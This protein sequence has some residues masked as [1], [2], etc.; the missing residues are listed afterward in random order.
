[1]PLPTQVHSTA[2]AWRRSTTTAKGGKSMID[3]SIRQLLEDVIDTPIKLQLVLLFHENSRLHGTAQ[4]V[5]NRIFRDIWST[6]EAL[7]ELHQD[8]ILSLCSSDEPN[9][10]YAPS[11]K[12]LE[13]LA[14]L[15]QAYNEPFERDQ[16][17]HMVREISVNAGY[18]RAK[19]QTH[20]AFEFHIM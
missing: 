2:D 17:Q 19:R 11:A 3:S 12:Y 6:R 1:M 16:V 20:G 7:H 13:P 18:R 14:Q 10:V 5:A 9:Y 8:G 15:V 4:Q